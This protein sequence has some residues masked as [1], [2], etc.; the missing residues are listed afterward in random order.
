MQLQMGQQQTPIQQPT[1]GSNEEPAGP[2]VPATAAGVEAVVASGVGEAGGVKRGM[3]RPKSQ[4]AA[5]NASAAAPAKAAAAAAAGDG[6]GEARGV[7]RGRGRPQKQAGASNATAAAAGVDK[8]RRSTRIAAATK[9]P[10]AATARA[11]VGGTSAV[12]RSNKQTPAKAAATKAGAAAAAGSRQQQAGKKRP[13]PSTEGAGC[14]MQRSP[15]N[16]AHS[17]ALEQRAA[18][19]TTEVITVAKP[20]SKRKRTL[21]DW[22]LRHQQFLQQRDLP[23]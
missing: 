22:E 13:M 20:G 15:R 21:S 7:K 1:A 19:V 11:A 18:A 8:Q 5:G 6:G 14:R 17:I 4:A 16:V 3:G 10:A 23:G 2:G 9:T 12:R